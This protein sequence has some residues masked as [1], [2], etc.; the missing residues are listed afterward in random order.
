MFY[1]HSQ[2]KYKQKRV[3]ESYVSG[4]NCVPDA[5]IFFDSVLLKFYYDPGHPVID[6]RVTPF[7]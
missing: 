4:P 7:W 2:R 1:T 3:K 5:S 6:N